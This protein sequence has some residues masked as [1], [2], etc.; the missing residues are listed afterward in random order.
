MDWNT[1]PALLALAPP[2]SQPGQPSAQPP[3][4]TS[5]VPLILLLVI[6]YFLL[7]RPQQK[8]AKQH[9]ELLKTLRPG[10]KIVTSSGIFGVVLTVKEKT[11]TLRSGDSKLEITKASVAEITERGSE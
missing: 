8:R 2:P 5:L 4:W 9:A 3:F 10:D 11:V 7:I 6:F 1:L